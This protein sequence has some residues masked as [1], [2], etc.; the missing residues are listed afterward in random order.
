MPFVM[1]ARRPI[2]P[3]PHTQALNSSTFT[4]PPLD[5][6]L[7]FAEIVEFHLEH[8]PD[9]PLFTYVDDGSAK[10]LTWRDV[11]PAVQRG[12]RILRD[13]IVAEPSLPEPEIVVGILAFAG[14]T[15]LEVLQRLNYVS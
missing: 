11:V 15:S 5:G 12:A 14:M 13:N 1:S 9:H 8:S 3:V 6:S 7:A 2:A 10:T 4:P